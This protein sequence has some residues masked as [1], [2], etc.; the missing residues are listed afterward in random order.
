MAGSQSSPCWKPRRT[1][2]V[3]VG[4]RA[5]AAGRLATSTQTSPSRRRRAADRRCRILA[6]SSLRFNSDLDLDRLELVLE[7]RQFL[8]AGHQAH[9]LLP[10]DLGLLECAEALA[11]VQDHE[12]VADWVRVMR[13]VGDEDDCDAPFARLQDVLED[14]P[15][16]LHAECR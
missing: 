11:T 3:N 2:A 6:A 16:L 13:V 12:A 15:R 9:E 1:G 8:A 14:D 7:L 4:V 10:V 5:A